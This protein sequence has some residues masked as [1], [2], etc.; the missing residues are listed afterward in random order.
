MDGTGWAGRT[1]VFDQRRVHGQGCCEE[2][3]LAGRLR[4]G[5]LMDAGDLQ[6]LWPAILTAV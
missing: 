2:N 5:R 4:L 6:L 1:V 3:R